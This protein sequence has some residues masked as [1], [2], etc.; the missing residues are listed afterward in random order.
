MQTNCDIGMKATIERIEQGL[1]SG[2]T[3]VT[4]IAVDRHGV[5]IG[6]PYFTRGDA[7]RAAKQA[8]YYVEDDNQSELF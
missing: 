7:V 3:E 8:G 4:W 2:G 6:K 5:T 1:L